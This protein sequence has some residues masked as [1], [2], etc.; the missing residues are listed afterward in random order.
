VK[1]K[2]L[3]IDSTSVNGETAEVITMEITKTLQQ[4]ELHLEYCRCQLYDNHATMPRVHCFQKLISDQYLLAVSAHCI[5]HFLSLAGVHAAHVYV[6]PV[7]FL[8]VWN[9]C[10]TILLQFIYGM[11]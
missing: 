7:T 4:D 6:H 2:E 11:C 5:N 1:I 10:L 8:L 9:G 3:V